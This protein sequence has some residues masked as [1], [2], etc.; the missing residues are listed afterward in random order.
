MV[1][2]TVSR[3]T[4]ANSVSTGHNVLRETAQLDVSSLLGMIGLLPA[5]KKKQNLEKHWTLKKHEKTQF[6]EPLWHFLW[7]LKSL[8]IPMLLFTCSFKILYVYLPTHHVSIL[9]LFAKHRAPGLLQCCSKFHGGAQA[10]LLAVE[11]LKTNNWAM[12]KTLA[13][14]MCIGDYTTQLCGDYNK[15]L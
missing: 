8:P 7:S 3:A 5:F 2:I 4:S 10:P 12:K 1:R 6:H 15:P 9:W 14:Y 13:I 11:F